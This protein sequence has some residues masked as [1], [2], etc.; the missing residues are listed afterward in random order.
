MKKMLKKTGKKK[1]VACFCDYF[2]LKVD[3]F[4]SFNFVKFY[5]LFIFP[6][7]GRELGS[8]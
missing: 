5:L 8:F 3:L 6:L 4:S 1:G 7:F 2:F